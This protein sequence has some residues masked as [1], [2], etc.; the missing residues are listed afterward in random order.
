MSDSSN[1]GRDGF[2]EQQQPMQMNRNLFDAMQSQMHMLLMRVENLE[3]QVSMLSAQAIT[4]SRSF[5]PYAQMPYGMPSAPAPT[6]SPTAGM[7]PPLPSNVFFYPQSG[8]MNTV[9]EKGHMSRQ[10]EEELQR[11]GVMTSGNAAAAA[12]ANK[13]NEDAAAAAA[14]MAMMHN[15]LMGSPTS[16]VTA[17]PAMMPSMGSP[18]VP[19]PA[20]HF[21]PGQQE[22]AFSSPTMPGPPASSPTKMSSA[23]LNKAFGYT[24]ANM[25][26]ANGADGMNANMNNLQRSCAVTLDPLQSTTETLEQTCQQTKI[27]VLCLK[28]C[29]GI[30]SLNAIARLQNLW[31]LNLQG[32]AHC[33]DDNAVRMIATFNTRL[34]RLNLCGCDRVTDAKPLSQL[35]FMFDLNLSG[36]NINNASLEAISHGC[37]QL[38]RLAINSCLQ[39]TDVSSV[40]NLSELKL[41]YCRYSENIDPATI[42]AALEGIGQ[43]LLTLNIDGIRFRQIELKQLPSVVALKNF[44]CKDNTLLGDLEWLFGTAAAAASFECLEMLDVEGCESLVNL[45]AHVTSLKRLKTVRLTHTG[46]TNDELARLSSCP[47]LAAVHIEE[48][49]GVTNVECLAQLPALTKVVL[50]LRMQHD[51]PKTNGVAVLRQRPGVEVVF[52]GVSNYHGPNGGANRMGTTPMTSP[53][54]RYAPSMPSS[55]PNVAGDGH[56]FP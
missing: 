13:A 41:L 49:A 17:F 38:S 27:R 48:C 47:A 22:V 45:G 34:S 31:L 11:L 52:A 30:T 39:L 15:S 33:V 50:D 8:V 56:L 40:R 53:T 36:T 28:S 10:L 42:G 46:V 44:N 26:G 55:S 21:M 19:N 51:D 35:S 43:N 5:Q 4:A 32:C 6:A 37:G 7:P 16:G 12:A 18:N 1:R 20:M 29:K 9:P 14:A 25:G 3:R 23:L 54:S 24:D 2:G